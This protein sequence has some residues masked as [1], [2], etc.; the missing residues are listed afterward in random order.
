[1]ENLA[2]TSKKLLFSLY[3][4]KQTLSNSA[5]SANK[6]PI[7]P[8]IRSNYL[9]KWQNKPDYVDNENAIDYFDKNKMNN[10]DENEIDDFDA[11]EIDDMD[12]VQ[13][14]SSLCIEVVENNIQSQ[15]C[16]KQVT[17]RNSCKSKRSPLIL[18]DNFPIDNFFNQS[19]HYNS[20][21][22]EDSNSEQS[23]DSNSDQNKH[24]IDQ[25]IEE[26][27]N[28]EDETDEE[29]DTII[30][31][32]PLLNVNHSNLY[33]EKKVLGDIYDEKVWKEFLDE[34]GHPFFI[35]D[36]LPYID[37]PRFTTIDPMH[38]IFLDT[39]DMGC[40]NLKI[41]SGFD[42][43]IADQWKIWV[44]VYSTY[45]L[46][47]FLDEDNQRYWQAFSQRIITE[48]KIEAGHTAMMAF[49]Q[50]AE[51]I[52]ELGSFPNSNRNIEL[53]VL[54]NF[55]Q[56]IYIQQIKT[57]AYHYLPQNFLSSLNLIT[58]ANIE[59]TGTL[60]HYNFTVQEALDFSAMSGG[61]IN[62][63]V[64]EIY[65]NY[66]FYDE[67]QLPK[68]EN[69][70]LY[71]QQLIEQQISNLEMK[72]SLP[73]SKAPTSHYLAIV[74]WYRRDSQKQSYF[75]IKSCDKIFKNILSTNANKT[76][77]AELAMELSY[78]E[79]INNKHGIKIQR[80]EDTLITATTTLENLSTSTSALQDTTNNILLHIQSHGNNISSITNA[81]INSP[82]T[83]TVANPVLTAKV[84][85]KMR[86]F[87][88]FDDLESQSQDRS[89]I[90]D[91]EH[92][93]NEKWN[94]TTITKICEAYF[95]TLKKECNT[96]L[97]A[98]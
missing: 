32:S 26:E 23:K 93:T 21:Q 68:S 52:Y 72:I 62:H 18:L 56:Q 11:N 58:Q 84:Y 40:I 63:I 61:L 10:F 89:Y 42:A 15:E 17:N 30:L 75:H 27:T 87:N 24:D 43:L 29:Y 4:S 98:K 90:Y 31:L 86:Y 76:Y 97:A 74:D 81:T 36:K 69:S 44:L 28:I 35:G 19:E 33:V 88:R 83:I 12:I 73:N 48:A 22:S 14:E 67:N 13:S 7:K 78:L 16:S 41:A 57:K 49:L 47:Q 77:Y 94:E 25:D 59:K 91:F 79:H 95:K 5:S 20:D 2:A 3:I 82:R 8:N 66:N 54:E 9:D 50:Y 38:N 46:Y 70:I 65:S 51:Q 53:E 34:Q 85:D 45:A 60:G 55:N 6:K 96:T 71:L 39:I 37:I 1:M 64:T 92:E 80:I